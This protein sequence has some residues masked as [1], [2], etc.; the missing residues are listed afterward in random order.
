[1]GPGQNLIGHSSKDK[2]TARNAPIMEQVSPVLVG[3][4]LYAA[5]FNVLPPPILRA[6]S[7]SPASISLLCSN[8]LPRAGDRLGRIPPWASRWL[9]YRASPPAPLSPYLVYFWSFI[10]AFCGL[11]V[12]Q[13]IF[14]YSDYFK[15]RHVPGIIASYVRPILRVAFGL[16]DLSLCPQGASAVLVYGAPQAPLAQPRAVLGGHFLSALIGICITKL[17]SLMPSDAKFESLRWL[18][19]SLSTSI[20]IVVMQVTDTTHPP[21]GATALLPAVDADIW[22]LSWYYLPVVLLSSVM[23][24]A[25]ALLI[26]N[27]QRA[28]P[29]YWI[30]PTPPSKVQQQ[31]SESPKTP[32]FPQP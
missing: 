27:I 12:L 22:N 17:F 1:M 2:A 6:G 3:F 8:M 21:A 28:Y 14:N 18:A 4:L 11:S 26:N 29:V 20:A 25:V 15:S 9:G 30:A 32:P 13:A 24:L 5:H 19:A 23:V 10:A 16:S 7:P 31:P